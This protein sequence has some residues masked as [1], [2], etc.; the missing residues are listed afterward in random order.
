MYTIQI[1]YLCGRLFRFS[2]RRPRRSSFR[3]LAKSFLHPL[4]ALCAGAIVFALFGAIAAEIPEVDEHHGAQE[5]ETRDRR[6][7]QVPVLGERAEQMHDVVGLH[8][9]LEPSLP[10]QLFLRT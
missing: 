10:P 1:L 9:R 4:V 6:G 7:D 8:L 2:L 3:L 5:D